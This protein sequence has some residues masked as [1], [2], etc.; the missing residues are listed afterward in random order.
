M[1]GCAADAI[2]SLFGLHSLQ[3]WKGYGYGEA[4]GPCCSCG[5][6][7]D[8]SNIE[9]LT[10]HSDRLSGAGDTEFEPIEFDIVSVS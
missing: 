7:S 3:D 6:C 9:G 5:C 10:I 8:G 1:R 4:Y 2:T